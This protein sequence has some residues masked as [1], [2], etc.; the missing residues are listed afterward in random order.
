[1]S[2]DAI[3]HSLVGA[4]VTLLGLLYHDIKRR[5]ERLERASMEFLPKLAVIEAVS[6]QNN[7]Q[8]RYLRSR[9]DVLFPPEKRK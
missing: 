3:L 1:M 5:V 8:L 6:N 7:E 4:V 2:V 9:I